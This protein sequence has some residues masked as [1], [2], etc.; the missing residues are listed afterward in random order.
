MTK[1]SKLIGVLYKVRNYITIDC[2]KSIYFSLG[3]PHFLFG[4]VIWGGSF[5]TYLDSLFLM[6]KK[7]LRV[8]TS[9]DRYAH[10]DPLFKNL[11]LLKLS[12]IITLQTHVFVYK[13]LHLHNVNFGFIVADNP[14]TRNEN[15]L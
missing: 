3:Y 11:N 5:T 12:D 2:L 15:Q 6:Q 4:S 1:I 14:I 13:A 10:T 8:M 7:L 9:S